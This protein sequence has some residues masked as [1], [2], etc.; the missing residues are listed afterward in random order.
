MV[1]SYSAP[2]HEEEEAEDEH[3]EH[4][5]DHVNDRVHNDSE[6]FE[7]LDDSQRPKSPK[8]PKRPQ[9][10]ERVAGLNVERCH[11]SND[12]ECVEAVKPVV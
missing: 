1:A 2:W 8:R 9:G 3:V 11:A 4:V 7:S 5:G 10:L 6:F 12:D